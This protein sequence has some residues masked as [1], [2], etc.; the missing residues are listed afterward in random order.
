MSHTTCV[1][2]MQLAKGFVGACCSCDRSALLDSDI[3]SALTSAIPCVVV[4][5]CAVVL[6]YVLKADSESAP[7]EDTIFRLPADYALREADVFR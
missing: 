1:H 3:Q 5:C 6:Q 4:A 2:S 7:T